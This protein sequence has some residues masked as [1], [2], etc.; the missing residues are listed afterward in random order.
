M[1]QTKDRLSTN[2]VTNT[3]HPA[4]SNEHFQILAEN[5]PYYKKRQ[6]SEALYIK[7][8]YPS[9]NEHPRRYPYLIDIYK[10]VMRYGVYRNEVINVNNE[11]KR[12]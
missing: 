11:L 9:L 5:L 12:Y 1:E 7:E 2:T 10:L 4:V 6:L 8:Q 3:G